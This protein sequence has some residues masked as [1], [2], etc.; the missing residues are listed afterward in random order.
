[1]TEDARSIRLRIAAPEALKRYIAVK[2]SITVDGISL[3][4]NTVEDRAFDL[5]IVPHTQQRT[6]IQYYRP[7][8]KV[9][10]EVDLVARY[11]ERLLLNLPEDAQPA[12]SR[13]LLERAGFIK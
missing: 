2:G 10:L 5:N 6:I 12:I 8:R 1:M 13:E 3:T 9:N 4:V 11:L 7:G